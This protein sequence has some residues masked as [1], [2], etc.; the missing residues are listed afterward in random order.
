VTRR[1]TGPAPVLITS[2]VALA[3]ALALAACNGVTYDATAT[4]TPRNSTTTVFVPTGSTKELMASI[5]ARVDGLSEQLVEGEGQREALARIQAE[6]AVVRPVIESQHPELLAGF[7]A[8]LAQVAR[9]VERRRPADADK[10]AKNLA[11][12]IRSFES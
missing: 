6:W 7:D 8:V 2:V 4:T 3:A 10:A 1:A 5:D 12:L 9:S 11:V